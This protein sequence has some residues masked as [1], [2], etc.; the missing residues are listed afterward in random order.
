VRSLVLAVVIAV[1][2][3]GVPAC[4]SRPPTPEPLPPPHLEP[5]V[6]EP[7]RV[8]SPPPPTTRIDIAV[9]MS[10]M[11][12]VVAGDALVWTD[13]MGAIWTVSIAGVTQ[14]SGKRAEP[15][16]LSELSRDGF[17][18]HPVV[19]GGEVF[20]S[21]K[22]DFVRVTLPRGP[23]TKLGLQLVEDPEDVAGGARAIYA[24][25][26]KRDD[27]VA[28]PTT[29]GR[30]QRLTSFR[31]GVL[32]VHGDALYAVSYATGTLVRIPT[33]GGKPAQLARGFSRPTALAV[34]DTAAFVY[35]EK[36]KTLRRVELATGEVRVLA[37][38]LVNSDDLVADGDWL[39]TYSWPSTL[40]RIAKDGSRREVLAD[41]LASPYHIAVDEAAVYVVSRDQNT[42]V[43]LAKQR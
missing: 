39:Y 15:V 40:L 41:D 32:A 11:S 23:V 6:A 43:R 7:P 37:G 24:T 25:L 14:V 30:A 10:P 35:T 12:A 22:R 27:V 19:V 42:I 3:A 2:V 13:G 26:F 9:G 16:Q 21:T 33:S 20:V 38:D 4:S 28:I 29:G 8:P 34:D 31:R 5:E 1:V 18:F 36:D 17:M